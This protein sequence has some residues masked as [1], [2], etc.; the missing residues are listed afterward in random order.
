MRR[1][2]L[3]GSNKEIGASAPNA[4]AEEN[5]TITLKYTLK[6]KEIQ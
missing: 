2:K 5:A 6:E 1:K 3:K 4:A